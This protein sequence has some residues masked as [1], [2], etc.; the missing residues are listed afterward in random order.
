MNKS[1]SITVETQTEDNDVL[2]LIFI[3]K[4]TIAL[5]VSDAA[6]KIH[7]NN[8]ALFDKINAL[9][10]VKYLSLER[11]E[12]HN[13]VNN[14]N[15]LYTNFKNSTRR[16]NKDLIFMSMGDME[17][18]K[19]TRIKTKF[20]KMIDIDKDLAQ[21]TE[22]SPILDVNNITFDDL[23]NSKEVCELEEIGIFSN[24]GVTTFLLSDKLSIDESIYEV[25][26][27]VEAG[28]EHQFDQYVKN[29]LGYMRESIYF[30]ENYHNSLMSPISYDAKKND[31][32]PK[33]TDKIFKQLGVDYV[34][35][36][37]ID[38]GSD[39]FINSEFGEAAINYY[40]VQ[41]LLFS[42][43]DK[44][45]YNSIIRK[46][47]P[48]KKTT[49]DIILKTLN[50]FKNLYYECLSL[51]F[52]SSNLSKKELNSQLFRKIKSPNK[53]I[54]ETLETYKIDRS[55]LGCFIFSNQQ[56]GLN[57]FSSD[58]YRTRYIFEQMK[59]YPELSVGSEGGFMTSEEKSK[60]T[61]SRKYPAYV[62]PI[63]FNVGGQ[64]LTMDRGLANIDMD[65]LREYRLLKSSKYLR[66][67]MNQNN[68]RERSGPLANTLAGF[69]VS[70]GRKKDSL[71]GRSTEQNI[72]PLIESRL[73]L[74]DNST[75]L[76]SDPQ[77]PS[78]N[79]SQI[80]KSKELETLAIVSDIV[81]RAFVQERNTAN[82][83]KNLR[84]SNP[85]SA[86][87]ASITSHQI[88]IE[89]IPPQVRATMVPSFQPNPEVDPLAN[90]QTG[91]ILQETQLN[92][93][94]VKAIVGFDR[95]SDGFMN[96]SSRIYEDIDENLLSSGSE[97]LAKSFEYELPELGIM[98]DKSNNTIYNNLIYIRG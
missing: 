11:I 77:T 95:S 37:R 59:Y 71:L 81:P 94:V 75:F 57:K 78:I 24:M 58:A 30:L 42:N 25:G 69:N 48:T 92:T 45:I 3:N 64:R 44:K 70:V 76:T 34:N 20:G 93:Y 52:D 19:I 14:K 83:L 18:K 68:G 97:I 87:R 35:A 47:L 98:K 36:D 62:T 54:A 7:A 65:R 90:Y 33:F 88:D 29:L 32:K 38:I 46:L 41:A 80:S 67:S 28:V 10:R 72:D 82:N 9:T 21:Y 15:S 61:S 5:E 84:L 66:D 1:I 60:F 51:F 89:S 63:G 2:S 17:S 12:C 4:N 56:S 43:P 23:L 13:Q 27:R 31:F 86:I 49:P 22:S 53:I 8:I 40:N 55:E 39:R 50:D 74:G 16:V 96:V 79:S 85:N 26:Y 73:Y 6:K 91:Q